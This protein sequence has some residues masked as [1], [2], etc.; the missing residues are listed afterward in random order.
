MHTL[1]YRGLGCETLPKR[2]DSELKSSMLLYLSCLHSTY[3]WCLDAWVHYTV[4][5]FRVLNTV[6]RI[7]KVTVNTNILTK[8]RSRILG[9]S[10]SILLNQKSFWMQMLIFTLYLRSSLK[11]PRTPPGRVLGDLREPLIYFQVGPT[12]KYILLPK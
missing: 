2:T 7:S 9:E 12:W 6:I 8:I 11:S 4:C 5:T 10:S 3:P 1:A